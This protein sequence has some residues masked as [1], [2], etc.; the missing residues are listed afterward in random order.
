MIILKEP[1]FKGGNDQNY[2]CVAP[3]SLSLFDSSNHISG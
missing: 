1:N 3:E 2:F